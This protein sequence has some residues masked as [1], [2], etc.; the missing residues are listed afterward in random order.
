MDAPAR[1]CGGGNA[2][3]EA[4]LVI[5]SSDGISEYRTH[6]PDGGITPPLVLKLFRD[7]GVHQLPVRTFHRRVPGPHGEPRD[8]SIFTTAESSAA[9]LYVSEVRC[10]DISEITSSALTSNSGR[11]AQLNR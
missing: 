1:F 2:D 8:E 4:C 6:N 3:E 11:A 7:F 9:V 10:T 5:P